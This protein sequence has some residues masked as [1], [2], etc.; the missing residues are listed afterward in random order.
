MRVCSL[1]IVPELDVV[2]EGEELK[3]AVDD[4]DDKGEH[5]EVDVGLQE[6]LLDAVLEWKGVVVMSRVMGQLADPWLLIGCL[7]LCSQ[8]GAQAS[9][10]TQLLTMTTTQKFPSLVLV[11]LLILAH[12]V[13]QHVEPEHRLLPYFKKSRV[14]D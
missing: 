9:L 3:D 1:P 8:L 4:R 13:A 5:E 12:Q 10:L 7:L 11:V 2:L 6:G 14:G